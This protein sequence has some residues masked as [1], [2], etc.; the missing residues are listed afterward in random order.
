MLE[1]PYKAIRIAERVNKGAIRLLI[2]D[3]PTI[4]KA[5]HEHGVFGSGDT[6]AFNRQVRVNEL[7]R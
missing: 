6:M 4:I 3:E 7:G 2:G 1:L 5:H